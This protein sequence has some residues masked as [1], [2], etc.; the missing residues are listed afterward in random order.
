LVITKTVTSNYA[1]VDDTCFRSRSTRTA[2]LQSSRA[3]I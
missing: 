3:G 1:A 2:S